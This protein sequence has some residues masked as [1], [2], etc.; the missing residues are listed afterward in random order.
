MSYLL[1]IGVW[2][3]VFAVPSQIIDEHINK[4]TGDSFKILLFFLRNSNASFD[5]K[6]ISEITGIQPYNIENAIKYWTDAGILKD[7]E[8]KLTP[9]VTVVQNS[10]NE[11]EKPKRMLRPDG[12]YIAKRLKESPE[13]YHI[14]HEA[15]SLLGKTL[16]P[17][18]SA[19]LL[20]AHDD[21]QLPVEVIIM[22]LSYCVSIGKTSTVFVEGLTK[23]W[24]EAGVAT[25][26]DAEAKIA[27]MDGVAKAWKRLCGL[28]SIPFRHPTKKE[29]ELAK[30]AIC[31]MKF[32]DEMIM[33]AY[34]KT[35]EST[36][37][38]QPKYMQKI[39]ENWHGKKFVTVSDV[40]NSENNARTPESKR[41]YNISDYE[42]LNVFDI[43]DVEE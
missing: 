1:D 10:T 23:N 40:R 34:E 16:S 26:Q 36:G 27:D 6:K 11:I 7:T 3:N 13:L 32:T 9:V 35:V 38:F 43:E 5:E 29:N 39:L 20:V 15:E 19:V 24:H 22:L 33:F 18:F 31:D 14:M 2:N 30:A 4:C 17:S 21:Y 41:S 42:K 25:M 12:I 37:K 8:G 28:M